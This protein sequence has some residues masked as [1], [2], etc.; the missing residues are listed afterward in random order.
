LAH[1][2]ADLLGWFQS[3]AQAMAN[4]PLGYYAL[5]MLAGAL[6]GFLA[7]LLGI[8]GGM[9][10]VPMLSAIFTAQQFAPDHIVHLCLATGMASVIFTSS[11]SVRSHH[12]RGAVD[13][14]IVK[15]M[16]L[17]MILGT[18]SSSFASGWIEQKTLALGFVA[19]VYGGAYQIYT[20]KKPK[21]GRTMP[22]TPWLWV[23]GLPIGFICGFVSAGGTFLTVPLML[24]FGVAMHTAVGTGAALG[25]PVA[26]F[27]TLGFI[28][29]GWKIPGLPDP[30]L[31]FVFLPALI[32]LVA[33]SVL[34]APLGANLAHRLPTQ[35]LKKVFALSLFLVATRM[36]VKYW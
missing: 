5:Y 7:G 27:G 26:L 23:F 34:T 6:V 20:G 12:A 2:S 18:L 15:R 19:I 4:L 29:S 31:G 9:M 11:S 17:P 8:G 21:A 25:V 16:A 33:V 32:A 30:H 3:A 10:L 35:T 1:L 28:L 22:S 24:Y 36:L 13:W 14:H